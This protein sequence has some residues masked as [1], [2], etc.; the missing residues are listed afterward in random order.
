MSGFFNYIFNRD[1]QGGVT[2]QKLC[3]ITFT[4]YCNLK[5]KH[6][7]IYC[8]IESYEPLK[9]LNNISKDIELHCDILTYVYMLEFQ[10]LFTVYSISSVILFTL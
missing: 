6:A 8:E 10:L 3:K 9:Q 5:D 4:R 2:I 7:S 1:A